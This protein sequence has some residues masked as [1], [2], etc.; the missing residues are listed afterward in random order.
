M[1]PDRL[2]LFRIED[3]QPQRTFPA[4]IQKILNA[5]IHRGET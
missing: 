3:N 1:K 5:P 2:P 4:R